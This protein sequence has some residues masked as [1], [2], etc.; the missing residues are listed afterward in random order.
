MT[1]SDDTPKT[2]LMARAQKAAEGPP[3]IFLFFTRFGLTVTTGLLCL[4][5]ACATFFL[6]T[7]FGYTRLS[8]SYIQRHTRP[9][10]SGRYKVSSRAVLDMA[11]RKLHRY[12]PR[13]V[14]VVISKVQ[15]RLWLRDGDKVLLKAVVSAG[16]GSVLDD[17][18]SGRHWVFDTPV[19]R[20]YVRGKRR[21]PVWVAPDWDYI[22]SGEPLPRNYGDR[23]QSGML[24]EYALD[25]GGGPSGYMIHGTLYDRLLG[26]NVS[27]GCIRVGRN[28]LRVVWKKVPTGATVF[29]Y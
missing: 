22:E 10:E 20:F 23:F 27:H 14:F 16:A 12:Q 8:P 29:M 6:S 13:G 15:N 7:G 25:L 1:G 4:V 17:P 3:R 5:F 26:R 28:D 21:N 2:P 9:L 18:K 24:G 19:G 11:E